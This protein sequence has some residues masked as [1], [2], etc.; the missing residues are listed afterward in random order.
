MMADIS[1]ANIVL[2]LDFLIFEAC[3]WCINRSVACL[4]FWQAKYFKSSQE[5]SVIVICIVESQWSM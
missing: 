3:I 1:V 4:R 5:S 2:H